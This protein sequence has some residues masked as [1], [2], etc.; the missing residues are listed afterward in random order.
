MQ[1][2]V[3]VGAIRESPYFVRFIDRACG[4]RVEKRASACWGELC[5]A[6]VRAVREPPLRMMLFFFADVNKPGGS[7]LESKTQVDLQHGI[8]LFVRSDDSG[9]FAV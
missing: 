2:V 3:N 9:G 6:I 5:I 1:S 7:F 8:C 4:A